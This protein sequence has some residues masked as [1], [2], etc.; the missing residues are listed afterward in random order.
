MGRER[1]RIGAGIVLCMSGILLINNNSWLL[2]LAIFVGG[3]LA[4]MKGRFRR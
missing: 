1:L 4:L 3:F 2:G